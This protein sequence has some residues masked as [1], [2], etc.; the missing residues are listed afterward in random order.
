[1][2]VVDNRCSFLV[3]SQLFIFCVDGSCCLLL[4]EWV[5][6]VTVDYLLSSQLLFVCLFV[7]LWC[8]FYL[9]CF[10]SVQFGSR[11]VLSGVL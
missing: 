4:I 1:M 5:V 9:F 10:L 8:F 6:V 2:S 7:C 11:N 3:Y